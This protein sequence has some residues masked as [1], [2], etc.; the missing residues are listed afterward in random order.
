MRTRESLVLLLGLVSLGCNHA[1]QPTDATGQPPGAV[2]LATEPIEAMAQVAYSGIQDRRRT[3]LR[4]RAE[5][6]AFWR[7]LTSNH[8]PPPP[9]PAI[10]F[11][12]RMVLVAAMGSRPTGGY[13][14]SIERVWEA[15]G[16]VTAVVR[17]VSPGPDCAVTQAFTAPVAAV[18]VERRDGEPTFVE[19]A[20]TRRCS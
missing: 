3:V 7:E 12:R 2:T 4:T 10:D 20:E 16:R 14:I 19:I 11:D 6:E 15:E 5:W 8:L 18:S 9:P 13:A 17:E 1:R